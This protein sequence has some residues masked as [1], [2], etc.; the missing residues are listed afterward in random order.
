MSPPG[1]FG[2]LAVWASG[3]LLRAPGRG[4]ALAGPCSPGKPPS[5]A[6]P[7]TTTTNATSSHVNAYRYFGKHKKRRDAAREAA[8]SAT[9]LEA[10]M[11]QARISNGG[12]GD[13]AGGAEG[14]GSG[15]KQAPESMD[16]EH[17]P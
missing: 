9:G 10:G 17:A 4:P 13:A 14:G 15:K 3:P 2:H 6:P 7:P 11:A 8:A 16:G 5:V 1:P 12:S